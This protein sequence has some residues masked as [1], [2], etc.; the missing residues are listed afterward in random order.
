MQLLQIIAL[1]LAVSRKNEKSQHLT[2]QELGE[3]LVGMKAQGVPD[4]VLMG[5]RLPSLQ[6]SRTRIGTSQVDGSGRGLFATDDCQEG[7]L[8]TC[9]PG[10]ILL[11]AKGFRPRP[12]EMG[13]Q[14]DEMLRDYLGRYCI[15][16]T[17]EYSIMGLPH[18]D[19]DVAYAGQFINDG[20][21]TPPATEAQLEGY[22]VES[23]TKVNAQFLPL[24]DLHMVTLATRDIQK[25][26]E[27]FV[28]YGPVYWIEHKATWR[29]PPV[30]M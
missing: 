7:D 2:W 8:L 13:I 18:L 27:I 22:V 1:S 19:Q 20:V 23:Q 10:D 16:V 21:A 14:N 3:I 11:H 12:S 15:G 5:T 9:Y 6:L 4:E 24:E 28:Y 25:G 29:D 26:E 30:N 17:D